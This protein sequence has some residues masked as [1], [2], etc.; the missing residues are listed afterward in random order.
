MTA[1]LVNGSDPS[2]VSRALSDLLA[3]LTATTDDVT[4]VEEFGL[5]ADMGD[6]ADPKSPIDVGPVLNALATPPWLSDHRIVV[7]R[8]A[9][10]LSSAQ[11]G[12][13][14]KLVTAAPTANLL[15]LTAGAKAVSQLLSK[16][17]KTAGGRVI[18]TDPGRNAR[19]RSDWLDGRLQRA[20]VHLDAGARKRLIDHLG[21]DA[22]R[23]DPI[24]E[25]LE[26][27]YGPGHKISTT[28]LEPLLGVEGAG[29][30]WELTD[31]IDAGNG[32]QAIRSLRRLLGPGGRH[33]LQV[34]A[35]LHRHISGML[36]LD[37]A[38]DVRTG[39]D[40]AALL[41][42]NAFPAKKILDQ[43]RRL[44]HDRI[45]RA[46]EVLA[47]ADADLRG[48]LAWPAELVMEVAVARLAQLSRA[49]ARPTEPRRRGERGQARS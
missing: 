28:D 14:A 8:D 46:V 7:V 24:L 23:V 9:G 39:D 31:A 21:E 47:G 22:A 37:G 34:L 30:P 18:D 45:V 2:L 1:F 40:A 25:L 35:T 20:S 43:C 13:I 29:P 16:A 19:A 49:T 6:G 27:T 12:E 26:V 4:E 3:E 38:G 5:L 36:R 44:G 11:A 32:E 10:F 33:P 17:V 41:G 42:M 48:R 15:V